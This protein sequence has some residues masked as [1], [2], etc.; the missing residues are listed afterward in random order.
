M[1]NAQRTKEANHYL[2]F[3]ALNEVQLDLYAHTKN[4]IPYDPALHIKLHNLR[5][6]FERSYL[7]KRKCSSTSASSTSSRT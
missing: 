1:L 5:A 7:M 2:V 6:N 4:L 3:S